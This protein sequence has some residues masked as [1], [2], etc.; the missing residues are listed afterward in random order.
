MAIKVLTNGMFK[1]D[2]IDLSDHLVSATLNFQAEMLDATAMTTGTASRIQKAG[3]QNWSLEAVLQQDYAANK[4]DAKL[5][6][7]LGTTACFDLRPDNS[8]STGIN[9][10]FNGIAI[11]QEYA[12]VSGGIGELLRVTA[13]FSPASALSRNTTAT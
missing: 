8:C 4:T 11:L 6:A 3:L 13:R 2:A 5:F 9:P 10:S 7:I 12:P 1:L